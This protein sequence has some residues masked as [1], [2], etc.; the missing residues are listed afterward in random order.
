MD[1]VRCVSNPGTETSKFSL[2]KNLVPGY[3]KA[4]THI[5]PARIVNPRAKPIE[6]QWKLGVIV[7]LILHIKIPPS[8]SRPA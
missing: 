3:R 1:K 5:I 8:T 6:E 2:F 4:D 7:R